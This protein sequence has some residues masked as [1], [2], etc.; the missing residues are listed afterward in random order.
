MPMNL[1][2][3]KLCR[4]AWWA[5]K[6]ERLLKPWLARQ[7]LG[8]DVLEL[9]PGFG[10]TTNLLLDVVPKLTVLEIDPASTQ[11]LREKFGD[12]ADVHEGSGAEMP[13]AEGRFSAVVCFTMLHHVPTTEL[14][15]AIFAE[16]ARVLR[17]G[18]RFCGTDSQLSFRFRLLHIG[19][20]MNVLDA[21]TLAQRLKKAGFEQ[22]EVQTRPKETVTF[23]AV[24]PG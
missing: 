15:D 4:S 10:A 24:K 19:D 8:D 16:A 14:Q 11:L 20:T 5:D 7:D 6:I 9:G 13:F 22:V 17:P 1:I 3:R 12:R 18:G 2:H 23:S 21:S